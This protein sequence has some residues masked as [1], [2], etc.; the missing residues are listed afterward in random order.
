MNSVNIIGNIGHDLELRHT[1]GGKA[2]I[3]FNVAIR[4]STDKTT[5]VRVV[6][7]EQTAEFIKKYFGKGSKIGVTGALK[8]N[9]YKRNDGTEVD[10]MEVLTFN[11]DILDKKPT[12][13]VQRNN[14]NQNQNEPVNTWEEAIDDENPF[15]SNDD[16][17]D[18]D[19][20]DLPF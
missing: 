5:W 16:V 9:K 3:N 4:E 11:V 12:E 10:S 19:S 6:A 20:D 7:W 2:V 18:I 8:E 13:N 15:E 14:Q 1:G 17:I